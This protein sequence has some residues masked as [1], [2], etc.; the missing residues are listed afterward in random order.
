MSLVFNGTKI[1]KVIYDKTTINKII[2][3]GIEVYSAEEY[4]IQN[5]IPT[6]TMYKGN[7][8][9]TSK[10]SASYNALT[11]SGSNITKK[12][13]YS[14]QDLGYDWITTPLLDVSNFDKITIQVTS[15]SVDSQYSSDKVYFGISSNLSYGAK[16]HA[17]YNT[18][19][20]FALTG[21]NMIDANVLTSGTLEYTFDISDIEQLCVVAYY[22]TNV[23]I[24]SGKT[25]STTINKVKLWN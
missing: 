6:V 15:D 9:N 18:Y 19:R 5:D 1:N 24:T 7:S 2:Y 25:K 23:G 20:S 12:F 21:L 11:L 13:D 16:S 14:K 8:T 22:Y 4:I 17:D 3:N 10:S